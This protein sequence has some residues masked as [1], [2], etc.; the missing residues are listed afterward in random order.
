MQMIIII[1]L[2]FFYISSE[3]LMVKKGSMSTLFPGSL[4]FL[5]WGQG[6]RDPGKDVGSRC[7]SATLFL[8]NLMEN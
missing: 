3:N 1:M 8:E 2:H 4:F 7:L 6:E 5:L